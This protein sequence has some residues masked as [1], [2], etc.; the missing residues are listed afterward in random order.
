MYEIFT[1]IYP[2]NGPHVGKYTIHGAYGF[3]GRLCQGE[4]PEG[5]LS[6]FGTSPASKL[7]KIRRAPKA[8]HHPGWKYNRIDVYTYVY[9]YI[10]IDIYST[11]NY[12]SSICIYVIY[13]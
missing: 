9:I 8:A 13:Q 10:S 12:G 2:I 6:V 1:N 3:E 11:Y 7:K 4:Q 5:F